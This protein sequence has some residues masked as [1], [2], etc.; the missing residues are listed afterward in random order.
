MSGTGKTTTAQKMGKVFYDMG[1]LSEAKVIECSATDLIGQYVGHTGPKVQK[2]LEKALGKVLFIDEAYRLGDGTNHNSFATEAMDEL[3]DCL[4][5]MVRINRI[6]IDADVAVEIDK[7]RWNICDFV[8]G[9]AEKV[10]YPTVDI[11]GVDGEVLVDVRVG[12]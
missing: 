4:I 10:L 8:D 9:L 2:M 3:V 6:G 12:I 5:G 7:V 11:V 1:F